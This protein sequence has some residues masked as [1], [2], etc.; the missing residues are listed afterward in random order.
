MRVRIP[1]WQLAPKQ[2]QAIAKAKADSAQPFAIVKPTRIFGA[3]WT[4]DKV[5]QRKPVVMCEECWRRYDGW[6]KR[7]SYRPDWGWRFIVN[8]DGCS[9]VGVYGTLFMPEEGFY[10]VLG[11]AHGRNPKP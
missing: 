3:C 10:S 8:C 6:W 4:S 11:P 1:L 2:I 5:A 7:A 9:T